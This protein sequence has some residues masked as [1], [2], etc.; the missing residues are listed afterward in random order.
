MDPAGLRAQLA[1]FR[2]AQVLI[3][4]SHCSD[5]KV[6]V[7]K[8]ILIL[9]GHGAGLTN[10]VFMPSNATIIELP[11]KPHVDRCFGQMA[12]ALGLDYWVVPQ[13]STFYVHAYKMDQDK[14]GYVA[15]LLRHVLRS[16]GLESLL[17]QGQHSDE[18]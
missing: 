7:R 4:S 15:R 18:L 3:G 9:G 12:Y 16:K 17:I 6:T 11:M 8:L 5:E 14:A 1:I 13:V 2:Q 10:L